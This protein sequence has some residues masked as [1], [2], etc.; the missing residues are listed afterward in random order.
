MP[1]RLAYLGPAGTF[2]EGAAL[3]HA[4]QAELIPC[5]SIS[6]VAEAVSNGGADEGVVPIENS[7]E[8]SVNDTLDMLI[9]QPFLFIR[10]ELVQPVQHCLLVRD[11]MNISDIEVIYS[12]PQALAQCRRYLESHFPGVS[13]EA[14]LSTAAAA[15]YVR[16]TEEPAGAIGPIRAA[17]LYKLDVLAH[18]IQDNPNNV[19][20]FAVLSHS[21]QGPTGN[22]KTSLCFSFTDDRPGL[23]YGVMKGFAERGINLAKIESR[24][25]GESLGTYIFLI[26]LDGHREETPIREALQHLE[27]QASWF[28]IFGSYPRYSRIS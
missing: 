19:T 21:D 8:G 26:D 4:P 11:G 16:E 7:L 3:K 18:G 6:A 13:A 23:L 17:E 2:S 14:A 1:H 24:P 12:H 27:E 20:R 9:H 5:P 22:D 28:R 15:K 25:T 10:G